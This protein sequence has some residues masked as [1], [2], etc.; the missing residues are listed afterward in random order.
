MAEIGA[1]LRE[2][3]TRA[4]IEIAQ[5]EAQTKIRAKYLRALENEEWELLP[6][7]TYVKSF[8]KTYGDMLGLD[9]RQ[10]VADYKRQHEPFQVEGD[11]GQLSKHSGGRMNRQQSAPP[12]LRN[13]ALGAL[14]VVVLGGAAYAF[15]LRG[16]DDPAAT[17]S[18]PDSLGDVSL[19]STP[20]VDVDEEPAAPKRASVSVLASGDATVCVRSGRKVVVKARDLEKGDRTKA[21]S[22]RVV[23][24]TAFAGADKVKLRVNG[25]T[26]AL[27]KAP[28]GAVTVTVT[29]TAV[30]LAGPSV[31]ACRV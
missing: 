6:G 1:A 5:M 3:R 17:P 2:A 9:G 18:T 20:A 27:P 8:L 15:V 10:L 29:P 12:L 7:P 31:T 24:V 13:V 4:R 28:A 11:I 21:A 16:D 30:K 19:P 22:G 26:R 23:V 14:A 25:K